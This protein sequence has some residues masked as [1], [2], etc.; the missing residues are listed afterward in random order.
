V[1]PLSLPGGPHLTKLPPPPLLTRCPTGACLCRA[2]PLQAARTPC[3]SSWHRADPSSPA[4][5]VAPSRPHPS[6]LL[7]PS[8]HPDRLLSAPVVREPFFVTEST[9]LLPFPP[10]LVR[11]DHGPLFFNLSFASRLPRDFGA[12]RTITGRC[13]PPEL[14]RCLEHCHCPQT[15]RPT[16]A[17]LPR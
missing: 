14:H 3:S 6:T 9:P 11:V 1:L 8:H 13:C 7:T 10:P 12:P 4:V 2:Q 5:P 16:G 15:C 17:A